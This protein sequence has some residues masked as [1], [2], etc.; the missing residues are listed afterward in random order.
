[1]QGR[2]RIVEIP[3]RADDTE[4][5]R[6]LDPRVLKAIEWRLWHRG[7]DLNFQ[8]NMVGSRTSEGGED[9]VGQQGIP[10]SID[11]GSVNTFKGR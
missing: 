5:G 1:M 9:G 7:R 3:G 4:E 11:E 10:I 6:L 8:W 2:G